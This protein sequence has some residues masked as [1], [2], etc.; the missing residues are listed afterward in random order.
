MPGEL[1]GGSARRVAAVSVAVIAVIAI[2]GVLAGWRYQSALSRADVAL[3]E[4]SDARTTAALTSEF[5]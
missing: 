1:Q 5:W 3:E 4:R 2:A